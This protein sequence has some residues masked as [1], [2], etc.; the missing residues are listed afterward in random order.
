MRQPATIASTDDPVIQRPSNSH[1]RDV[2]A[3]DVRSLAVVRIGLGCILLW[4]LA[5]RSRFLTQFYTDAGVI[6]RSLFLEPSSR[7]S[8]LYFLVGSG[9]GVASLFVVHALFAAMLAMGLFTRL[10]AVVCL[11]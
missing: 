10:A 3:V 9:A 6:P 7:F 11:V 4:D 8:S 2:F 5:S 1:W